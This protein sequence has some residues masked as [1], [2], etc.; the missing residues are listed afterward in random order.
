MVKSL[1]FKGD[2]KPKKRKRA[3]SPS[4]SAPPSTLTTTTAPEETP[5]SDADW[6]L[7]DSVADITGPVLLV[8]AASTPT[9]CLASDA[10]GAVFASPVENIIESSPSSAEPSDVRQVW[11]A[12]KVAGTEGVSFK[13]SHGRYL[14]V[15]REGRAS[16][17]REARGVE[18][19]FVLVGTGEGE[20]VE[21]GEGKDGDKEEGKRSLGL[22]TGA[23]T[24]HMR[25]V[26]GTYLTAAPSPLDESKMLLQAKKD[27]M[28]PESAV[29]VKMQAKFK[30]KLEQAKKERA[31][32]KI[33]RAQ[34]ER[35]AGRTLNDDEVKR[36][37]KARKRGTYHEEMLDVRAKGK[38]DKF[39]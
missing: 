29:I 14:G 7:A 15:D 10:N 23:P 6:V 19:G 1:T 13:G 8:F 22:H 24:F 37:K 18:E 27:K 39:A 4:A 3:P 12:T 38:H 2:P 33:G 16:A 20:E 34:I 5:T 30:P 31:Y 28:T 17:L 26:K 36:L 9:S 35:E 25:T 32:E 11:I 21:G